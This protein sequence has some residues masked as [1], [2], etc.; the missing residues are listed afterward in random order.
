MNILARRVFFA[1]GKWSRPKAKTN[2]VNEDKKSFA[3]GDDKA[4]K[5]S[6]S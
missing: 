5:L 6:K 3:V 1:F 2:K 4:A